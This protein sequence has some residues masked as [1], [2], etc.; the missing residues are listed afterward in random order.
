MSYRKA[1]TVLPKEL[2]MLVQ[3]YAQGQYLYIPRKSEDRKCW[4]DNTDSKQLLRLRDN[5]IY[6]KYKNGMGS[7]DLSHE[8]YLSIKSIQRIIFNEKNKEIS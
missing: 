8:Y 4:G 3:E 6:H 2:L 5:E 7:T 1:E